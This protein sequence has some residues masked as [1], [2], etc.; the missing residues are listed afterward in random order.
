[1]TVPPLVHIGLHKTG[2]TW[3]QEGLFASQAGVFE[4][5][6]P[7]TEAIELLV[8]PHAFE[9]DAAAAARRLRDL[10]DASRRTGRVPVLSCEALSG[11]PHTGGWWSGMVADR[12]AAAMPQAR[13]LIMVRRQADMLASTWRQFVL[14]GGTLSARRY[15]R[16]DPSQ[17]LLPAFRFGHF[18]YDRIVEAYQARFGSK[19]VK[20][21]PFEHLR[22]DPEALVAEIVE[23]AEATPPWG[24]LPPPANRGLSA[25]AL[26]GMRRG[27][28]LL[29]RDELNPAAPLRVAAWRRLVRRLDDLL[30]RRAT[31]PAERRL[32]AIAAAAANGRFAASNARLAARTGL[33]LAAL[34]YELPPDS[35]GG[36]GA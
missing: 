12:L 25:L 20:V 24:P 11:N 21:L 5:M 6:L 30:L 31:G 23:F 16:E 36:R 10:A 32:A 13:I 8:R 1:M 4:P 9:W 33:D 2:T 14:R 7:A 17:R 3:L 15:L 28:R 22:R 35:A 26:A 29:G 27:N 18:E 19:Q 34:G